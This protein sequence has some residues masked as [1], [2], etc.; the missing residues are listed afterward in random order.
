MKIVDYVKTVDINTPSQFSQF[1][2]DG[3]G[4][5]ITECRADIL[6][7]FQEDNNNSVYDDYQEL[8]ESDDE[9][10]QIHETLASIIGWEIDQDWMTDEMKQWRKSQRINWWWELCDESVDQWLEEQGVTYDPDSDQD[11]DI[12]NELR[13]FLHHFDPQGYCYPFNITSGHL[14]QLSQT[15]IDNMLQLVNRG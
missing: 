2:Y 10:Y 5:E 14:N 9:H 6:F 13:S 11:L 4:D 12:L 8:D 7:W 1:F 15:R 3:W